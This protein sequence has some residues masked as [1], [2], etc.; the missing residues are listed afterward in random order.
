MAKKAGSEAVIKEVTEKKAR[1]RR[2]PELILE[3]IE[4]RISVLT[5]RKKKVAEKFLSEF[6][7]LLLE[8]HNLPIPTNKEEAEQTAQKFVLKQE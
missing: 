2:P 1:I 7:F 4:A 6:A 3:E 5:K 8:K